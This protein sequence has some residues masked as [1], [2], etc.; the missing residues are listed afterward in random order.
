[1]SVNIQ[2]NAFYS[3]NSDLVSIHLVSGM[4]LGLMTG[5]EGDV[6]RKTL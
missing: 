5:D 6:I 4:V 1:M 3:F 2:L